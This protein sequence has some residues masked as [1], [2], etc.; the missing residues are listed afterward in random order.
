MKIIFLDIDGVLNSK[1]YEYSDRY[2]R[3]ALDPLAVARLNK[4]TDATNAKI[5]ISSAWRT[6]FEFDKDS[7]FYLLKE[8]G[9]TGEMIDI[10]PIF[11]SCLRWDEIKDWLEDH[12]TVENFVI[13]DDMNYMGGLQEHLVLTTMV[14][15]LL[16][17][18]VDL[19]LEK[20][21]RNK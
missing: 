10:T 16:D 2:I 13:L 12:P 14:E 19:V 6:P 5:V 15:G 1:N 18:H 21:L 8:E 7:L 3:D 9:I 17:S 11:T 20:L 4:I